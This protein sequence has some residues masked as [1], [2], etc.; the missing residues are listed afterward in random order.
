[1]KITPIDISKQEFKKI[2][3]GYD[4][5]E[6]DTFL[7]MLGNEYEN[8]IN[9]REIDLE[10]IDRRDHPFGPSL[11]HMGGDTKLNKW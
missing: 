2:M 1:M 7:E 10:L 8:L 11:K 4:P 9:S 3:R 5:V 6:V